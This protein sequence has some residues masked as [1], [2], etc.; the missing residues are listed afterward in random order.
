MAVVW[1]GRLASASRSG[2]PHRITAVSAAL[3]LAMIALA[4]QGRAQSQRVGHINDV[5]ALAPTAGCRRAAPDTGSRDS[6]ALIRR[7]VTRLAWPQDS[8]ILQD[9]LLVRRSTVVRF[10]VDAARFGTGTFYFAPE[11]GRCREAASAL[12]VQGI[13]PAAGAAGSYFLNGVRTGT[14]RQARDRLQL[15]VNNG[16]VVVEWTSGLL[17]VFALGQEIRDSGTVFA[18]IVDSAAQRA[19]VYVRE[20]V[21]TMAAGSIRAGEGEAI[22]FGSGTPPRLTQL[23]NVLFSEARYHEAVVWAA[24]VPRAPPSRFPWKV[25]GGAGALGGAGLGYYLWRRSKD[26]SPPRPYQGSIVIRIPL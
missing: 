6:L 18:V 2:A 7:G 13:R 15:T 8:A 5:R 1:K 11:L 20:G 22:T 17:S 3:V 14:G 25:V 9:R 23:Q 26:D 16:G 24:S 21:V 12:Q 4:T 10:R 19:V